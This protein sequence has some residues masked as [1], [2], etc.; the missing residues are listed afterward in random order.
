MGVSFEGHSNLQV[1][2][3]RTEVISGHT[4]PPNFTYFQNIY[5]QIFDAIFEAKIVFLNLNMLIL[6]L[7]S[8][9]FVS[10]NFGINRFLY[11]GKVEINSFWR[12]KYC[13]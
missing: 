7:L 12:S 5:L 9:I 1:K 13:L 6:F 8:G 4:P 11:L 2:G 10:V 3:Q